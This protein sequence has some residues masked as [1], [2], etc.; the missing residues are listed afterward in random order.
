MA[1]IN[2]NAQEC[3]SQCKRIAAWL[4]SGRTLTQLEALKLFGCF[5]L[6]SR[7]FDLR[8]KGLNIQKR[9]VTTSTGKT[10]CEYYL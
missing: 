2:D 3:A 6:A 5:R 10:V 7:V 8:E 4:K 9:R 1:N